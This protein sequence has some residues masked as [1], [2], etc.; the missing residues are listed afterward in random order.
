MFFL[1]KQ[2]IDIKFSGIIYPNLPNWEW[3]V[4]NY[5][6]AGAGNSLAPA[7]IKKRQKSQHCIFAAFHFNRKR[8]QLAALHILYFVKSIKTKPDVTGYYR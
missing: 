1:L 4:E 8:K 5:R 2:A 7:G 6:T 3:R